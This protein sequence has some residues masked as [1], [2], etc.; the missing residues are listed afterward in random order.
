[1]GR[2]PVQARG[3]ARRRGEGTGCDRRLGTADVGERLAL[4]R[5][6]EFDDVCGHSAHTGTMGARRGNAALRHRTYGT[7]LLFHVMPALRAKKEAVGKP[8]RLS[9][10]APGRDA[11]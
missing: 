10:A 4:R 6:R 7:A 9:A 1:F 8:H 3:P 2:L 11:D 5:L